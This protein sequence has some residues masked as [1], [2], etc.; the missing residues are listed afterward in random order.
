MIHYCKCGQKYV[1][2]YSAK[3]CCSAQSKEIEKEVIPRAKRG[4]KKTK[5]KVKV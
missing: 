1:T 5:E 4:L 3:R 2:E